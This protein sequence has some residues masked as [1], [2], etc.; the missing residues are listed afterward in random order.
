MP[1]ALQ[2][3]LRPYQIEGFQWLARLAHWGA[4]ACLADDMGLGKT[5]QAIAM[6]LHRAADGAALVVAPTSVCPNW[7]EEMAR[8]AP[9]LNIRL[10]GGTERESLI[11]SMAAFDVVVCSYALLQQETLLLTSRHWYT[12]VLDEAQAVKNFA[13]KRA[14]AVLKLSAEFRLATTGTPVENRLDE[15]WMLFRFLNPGL[16]GSRDI[17]MSVLR[18]QSNAGRMRR[19]AQA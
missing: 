6:L 16:L 18:C 2:A 9:T 4:G 3:E 14:Q 13:T 12:L 1:K 5:V 8:F 11:E 17:S 19:R 10:F 7:V 15:L